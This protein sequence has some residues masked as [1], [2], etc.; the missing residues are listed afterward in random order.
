M[1]TDA[2]REQFE[3]DLLAATLWWASVSHE[4]PKNQR[5]YECWLRRVFWRIATS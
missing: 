1:F 4:C 2:I 5:A 3:D